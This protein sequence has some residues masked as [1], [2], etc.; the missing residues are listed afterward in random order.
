VSERRFRI[1]ADRE[2]PTCPSSIPWGAILAHEQQA[3]RNHDQTIECLNQR[4]GL[5]P[6]EAVAV[7]ENRRWK[8]MPDRNEAVRRLLELTGMCAHCG[9]SGFGPAPPVDKETP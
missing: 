1:M 4:G 3:L 5:A 9:G 6:C 8:E 7:L 2:P